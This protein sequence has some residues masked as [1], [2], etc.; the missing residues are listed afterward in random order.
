[1]QKHQKDCHFRRN[2]YNCDRQGC[3]QQDMYYK[4]LHDLRELH[5]KR[6]CHGMKDFYRLCDTCSVQL[7]PGN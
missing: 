7:V 6:N 5:W 3:K 2:Q 1:M 4:N